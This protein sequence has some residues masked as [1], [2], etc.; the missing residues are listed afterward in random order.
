ML[1]LKFLSDLLD[2]IVNEDG[3]HSKNL[4]IVFPEECTEFLFELYLKSIAAFESIYMH[5]S[6]LRVLF[7]NEEK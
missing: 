6:V 4:S 5:E 1:T 2:T 7:L 3:E